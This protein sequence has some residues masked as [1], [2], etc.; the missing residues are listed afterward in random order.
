VVTN[1]KKDLGIEPITDNYEYS[2]KML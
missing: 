2:N 1:I